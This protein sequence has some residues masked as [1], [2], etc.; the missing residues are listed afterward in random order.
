MKK[1]FF[2]FTLAS[3]LL[4]FTAASFAQTTK[5]ITL[6]DGSVLKGRVIQLKDDIY[7][8]ETSTLGR[9]NI[10]E[11]KILSIASPQSLG[12]QHQPPNTGKS[13]QKAELKNQVQQLQGSIL[14][15]PGLMA[16]LQNMLNDEN[17]K[18]MLSDPK[19]MS[20]VLSYDQE[21]IQQNSNVQRLMQNPKMRDLMN[22]V[23]QRI[24]IQK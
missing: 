4:G 11:S 12:P 14:T 23:H 5:T 10:P 8:L 7:T 13:L 21:K 18:A 1:Y 2:I 9:I 17:I 15:D 19:L 6:K 22:K 24:P 16:E 3:V 20:D